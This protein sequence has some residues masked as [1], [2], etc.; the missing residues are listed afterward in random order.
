MLKI[1]LAFI[2]LAC[3]ATAAGFIF[4][5]GTKEPSQKKF[6]ASLLSQRQISLVE[7]MPNKSVLA[8]QFLDIMPDVRI[9]TFHLGD[10]RSTWSAESLLYERY[11]VNLSISVFWDKD[12]YEFSVQEDGIVY[13]I[14][15]IHRITPGPNGTF[16]I[17]HGLEASVD[18]TAVWYD[19]LASEKSR[20]S[21]LNLIQDEPVTE[22]SEYWNS[23]DWSGL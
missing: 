14:S 19:F 15:E 11:I 4:V 13:R 7:R 5:S 6:N 21:D 20:F 22:L 9:E 18:E 3:I 12:K 23:R 10:Q 2:V 1:I 17:K 8:S 16:N